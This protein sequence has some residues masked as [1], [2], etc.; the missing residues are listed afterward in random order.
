MEWIL[1]FLALLAI[2]IIYA[3]MQ[4]P[5][6]THIKFPHPPGFAR[7]NTPKDGW[8]EERRRVTLSNG[9]EYVIPIGAKGHFV[10]LHDW[11]VEAGSGDSKVIFNI[12]AGTATDF[13]S[14]PKVAHSLISPISNSVYS[15]VLH[16]YLY[17]DP[18]DSI[19]S[20]VSKNKAD[21]LFYWG[22]RACGVNKLLSGLMYL[23][24]HWF[25]KSSYVR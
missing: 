16:D 6:H 9:M 12:P 22:L 11:P 10:L 13:A 23:A 1:I 24:V 15:A 8:C 5:R 25:G 18:R 19:A 14:I 7:I 20:A 21:S 3:Y 4:N 2:I 17:K